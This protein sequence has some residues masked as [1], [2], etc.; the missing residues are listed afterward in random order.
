MSTELFSSEVEKELLKFTQ[1][2]LRS[3]NFADYGA[4]ARTISSMSSATYAIPERCDIAILRRLFDRPRIVPHP[5]STVLQGDVG[6]GSCWPMAG[7]SGYITINLSE[8]IWITNVTVDHAPPTS[9]REVDSAPRSFVLWAMTEQSPLKRTIPS[10][11]TLVALAEFQYDIRYLW[12]VQT[13]NIA[14]AHG[15]R[16]NTVIFQILDNWG[17]TDFTC[18]YGLRVRGE[19]LR[20]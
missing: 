17:S 7:S 1:G 14:G 11:F 19:P 3:P 4:G 5:P 16:A 12:H 6:P 9:P 2:D 8:P 18:L 10:G 13:F 20:S 15:F